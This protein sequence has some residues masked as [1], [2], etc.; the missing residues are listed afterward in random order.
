MDQPTF[1][2][3][4]DQGKWRGYL[5]GYPDYSAQ[6]ESFEDLQFKLR[7]LYRDLIVGKPSNVRKIA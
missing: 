3:S 1:I 7:Q 6:G 4:Q 2:F 5:Q